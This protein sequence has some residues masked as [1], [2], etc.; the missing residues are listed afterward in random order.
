MGHINLAT[1][2]A[3]LVFKIFTS[4]IALAVDMK[5]KEIERVLYF[6]NFIVIE[7]GL[8]GL[9]KNQLLNEEELAKYQDE[10]DEAFTTGIGAEAVLKCLKFRF[11]VRTKK[12]S[13]IY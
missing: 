1:P 12:S 13:R 10:F 2:V 7:P 8:T 9:K 4:R 3:Y 11:R 6:E 5:L